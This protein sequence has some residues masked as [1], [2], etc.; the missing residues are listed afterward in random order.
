MESKRRIKVERG[1]RL[2]PSLL[3]MPSRT[4]STNQQPTLRREASQARRGCEQT[5][6]SIRYSLELEARDSVN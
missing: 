5:A 1:K 4:T 3:S 6:D 2:F